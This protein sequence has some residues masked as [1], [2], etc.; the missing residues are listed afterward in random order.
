MDDHLAHPQLAIV[1]HDAQG[2]GGMEGVLRELIARVHHEFRVVVISASLSPEL[3]PLVAW[4][5][6]PVPPWPAALKFVAFFLLAGLRLASER[7]D[8]V[9]VTGAIV[10]N[11]AD[12]A[13]VH[14]CHAGFVAGTGRLAPPGRPLTRR[15][16]TAVARAVAL[17]AERWCYRPSRVAVLAAVSRGVAVELAR[18]YPRLA[19]KVTPNG[20][21]GAR[22]RPDAAVRRQLRGAEGVDPDEAVAV[23]VGSDWD[24]KGLAVALHGLRTARDHDAHLSLWVVGEGDRGRFQYMAER[25]GVGS[26]VRFFGRRSDT[27]RFYQA[28]DL[29]LFPSSYEAFSLAALEAASTGLPLVITAVNGA[30]EL[31]GDGV[32]GVVVEPTPEAIG[33]ALVRLAADPGLRRRLGAGARRRASLFTWDRSIRSVVALYRSVLDDRVSNPPTRVTV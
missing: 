4:R 30:E 21:D 32:A 22:F 27:E 9:H 19:V 3:R 25:L 29:L 5:R 26:C 2:V 16:N 11:R 1:A 12:V 15:V 10:P 6:V 28:A 17:L 18:H 31:V 20:V 24:R 14:F 7:V 23:F 33:A 13:S 8:L